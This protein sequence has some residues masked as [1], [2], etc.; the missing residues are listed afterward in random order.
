MIIGFLLSIPAYFLQT[1]I[2]LLP[3]GGQMPS[4]WV[5]AVYTIWQ[6]IETFSFIVPIGTLLTVLGLALTFHLAI[7]GFKIFHWII[8]K[9]PFVG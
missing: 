3:N 6:Y 4:E 1:I 9:I 7:F 2:G 8:T 5:S